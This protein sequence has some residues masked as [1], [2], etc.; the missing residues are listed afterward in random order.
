M[1]HQNL[2]GVREPLEKPEPRRWLPELEEA[3][4]TDAAPVRHTALDPAFI[5]ALR[6]FPGWERLTA[7]EV[8]VLHRSIIMAER[9]SALAE[10]LVLSV[11]T[12][13]AHLSH[14]FHKL[15]HHSSRTLTRSLLIAYGRALERLV[16]EEA[17]A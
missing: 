3:E 10:S 17:A 12:V 6:T 13:E 5:A 8:E 11:K 15:G 16:I 2:E 9:N 1:R 14:I 4:A 7:R